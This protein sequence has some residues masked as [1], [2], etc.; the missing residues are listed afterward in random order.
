MKLTLP[1]LLILLT[2]CVAKQSNRS[3][4]IQE[5]DSGVYLHTSYKMVEGYGWVDS[6][7]L[8]VVNDNQAV[9][10]DTPWSE[11]DT[12]VLISW[13]S[14]QEFRIE[15]SISTHFHEDR[16]AGI[17][18]L[19]ALSIP[20]YSSELTHEF[21][22]KKDLPTASHVFSGDSLMMQDGLI[23]V[24]Y[25]GA[26]HSRDNLV[27]WLPEKNLLFGGCLVRPLAWQSLGF[28]GDANINQWANSISNIESKYPALKTIVPGH[29]V[30]GDKSILTHTKNIAIKAVN[31][32]DEP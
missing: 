26:G 20:T 21:L 17:G 11:E 5:I 18:L 12:E 28:T 6:N 24:Y 30:M 9:I 25:P 10:V 29:G 31:A 32:K 14:A 27:V 7:G 15:A 22:V 8:V 16:T 13:I 3:L 4:Q 1:I 2:G 19:N 23:E